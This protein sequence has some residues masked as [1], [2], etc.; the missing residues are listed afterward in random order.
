MI[1]KKRLKK[2]VI[3]RNRLKKIAKRLYVSNKMNFFFSSNI[4][5]VI[6]AILNLFFFLQEDFTGTKSKKRI[7]ANKNKN[8]SI[9]MH[10][11]TSKRKKVA[12]LAF[13]AFY[14]FF[15]SLF[16]LFVL[17]ML[18]IIFVVLGLFVLFVCVKS[19]CKKKQRGLKLP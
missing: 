1:K 14:A 8:D 11:K 6:R 13:C 12:C 4:N 9:F 19:S 3:K 15:C 18:L 17:F 10:I 2:I 5:E 7:Q 16:M